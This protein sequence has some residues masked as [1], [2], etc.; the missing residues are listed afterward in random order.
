MSKHPVHKEDIKA[1]LRKRHGSLRAFEEERGLPQHSARD[2]LRGRAVSQTAHAIADELN[3]TV[4]KLFPG[5]F[6]SHIRDDSAHAK[7]SHRQNAEAR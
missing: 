3:T 4:D 2:V 1:E 5:R 6:K 7:P